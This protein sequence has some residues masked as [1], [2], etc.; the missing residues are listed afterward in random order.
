MSGQQP[1][2]S[3]RGEAKDELNSWRDGSKDFKP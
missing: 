1:E 3:T 2:F